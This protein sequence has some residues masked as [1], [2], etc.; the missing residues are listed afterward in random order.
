MIGF[1]LWTKLLHI[2][3]VC[4]FN[5][6]ANKIASYKHPDFETIGSIA[7]AMCILKGPQVQKKAKK[8]PRQWRRIPRTDIT[9]RHG[10]P[11]VLRENTL[12][13][14]LQKYWKNFWKK[15]LK[16]YFKNYLETLLEKY[17]KIYLKK[18]S[19]KYLKILKN[20]WKKYFSRSNITLRHDS[21]V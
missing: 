21:P 1:N 13:C 9:L 15:Y 18:C 17:L 5:K 6:L 12:P 3:P 8:Q 11:L 7:C 14:H 16:K 20:Y 2:S 19:K 4:L 10:S